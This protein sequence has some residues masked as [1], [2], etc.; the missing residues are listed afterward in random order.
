MFK[1]LLATA[2]AG[3]LVLTGC[4]YSK[5]PSQTEL[6]LRTVESKLLDNYDT[7]LATENFN[8]EALTDL[9]FPEQYRLYISLD[10][11]KDWYETIDLYLRANRLEPNPKLAE[12]TA[13]YEELLTYLATNR[14]LTEREVAENPIVERVEQY[15]T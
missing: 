10:N 3:T 14:P 7:L 1:S 11:E 6:D 12:A 5:T 9:T 13:K 8:V 2:W 4:V 15:L